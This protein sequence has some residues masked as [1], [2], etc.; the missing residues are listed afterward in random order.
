MRALAA[1]PGEPMTPP[2]PQTADGMGASAGSDEPQ[3]K[4]WERFFKTY[5]R[6]A[7][8]EAMLGWPVKRSLAIDFFDLQSHDE[9]LAE[10]LLNHPYEALAHAQEALKSVDIPGMDLAP[11]LAS[12]Q[13]PRLAVRVTRLPVTH[14]IDVRD[15]RAEHLG[16][17]VALKGL[18]K[19][20]TEVRPKLQDA[21]F[22]CSR[23]GNAIRMPQDEH[24]TLQEPLECYEDQGG[25]GRESKF[26]LVVGAHRG[27]SSVWVDTQKLEIQEAPENMRGGEQPQR[28]NLFAED[29]LC[30]IVRP[31]ERIT[32][33]GVLRCNVRKDHGVKSTI[34]ELF[35]EANAVEK[36]EQEFEEITTTEEE[37]AEIRQFA[38]DAELYEKM[39]EAIAPSLY[40]LET[41]KMTLL[42]QLFGGVEKLLPDK[43]RLRGDLH[44]LLVGDPG[45]AKS[46]LIRYMSGLAPRGIYTSGK[47]SSGAG[48][49]AAA[50]KDEFGEGRW[51]LEAGAMVLA[52]RGLL[53]VDEI[54]KMDKNDQSSMH[55]GMEQQSIS[56]AK[57]GITATLQSRCSVLGA[58][59]PKSGRFDEFTPIAEQI[60]F[61]P[62]LLSRFDVI[63]VLKDQPK[64][65]YDA[66]LARF[67]LNN[68]RAGAMLEQL[69]HDETTYTEEQ[70]EALLQKAEP[71]LARELRGS[72][73]FKDT[74]DFLRKYVAYA[75][76]SC[77]PVLSEE[78]RDKLVEY[79]VNLRKQAGASES[80]AIPLTARQLEALVR[81]SEASARVRLAKEV[82]ED[83]AGRAISIYEYYMR[84][85]GG[86]EGGIMDVDMTMSPMSRSQANAVGTVKGVI[87]DLAAASDD[88]A[89][90]PDIV[91]E[92]ER[93]GVPLAKVEAIVKRLRESGEVYRGR[94]DNHFKLA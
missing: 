32:V 89:D 59:N 38:R 62:A 75:K 79:Y 80:K 61:P 67:I 66:K 20:T 88:G 34:F 42:L 84:K 50:V 5:Y 83:D 68:H 28:L 7:I 3:V 31:G 37:E 72:T 57:A 47:S 71:A 24:L 19:K 25:C 44:V 49:T 43:T 13:R 93:Q 12:G 91:R 54:D 15:L 39:R 64:V 46:Q 22:I 17:L 45:V 23:C 26:K 85:I 65:D 56:V 9:N 73:L 87:R 94:T 35:L 60:N 92:A 14:T 27:Q 63:F 70:A 1:S 4:S 90:W 8:N 78:A 86:S 2:P 74:K 69:R 40:G 51:T 76:R 33:N 82:E 53:C 52:D 11:T 18:V 48:L 81:M 21:V 36:H 41:E 29:D 58:A 55:E 10:F 6:E 30:G 77:H 16:K